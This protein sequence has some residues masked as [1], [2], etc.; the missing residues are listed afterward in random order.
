MYETHINTG[1][2]E[3]KHIIVI[4]DKSY[5]VP[6]AEDLSYTEADEALSGFDGYKAFLEKHLPKKVVE[7]LSVRQI[8]YI[9]KDWNKYSKEDMGIKPGESQA[10]SG[11]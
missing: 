4:E 9:M 8:H 6:L 5:E 2:E 1:A 10:L 7:K 11:S 3:L